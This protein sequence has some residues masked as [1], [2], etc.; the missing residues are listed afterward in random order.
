M[1][2]NQTQNYRGNRTTVKEDESEEWEMYLKW[3][4]QSKLGLR[5]SLY[6]ALLKAGTGY[7][8]T[9]L[10]YTEYLWGFNSWLLISCVMY[11][12]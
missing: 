2:M 12:K 1:T 7:I 10:M 5:E 6:L 11:S 9:D 8:V 3:Q 4:Q